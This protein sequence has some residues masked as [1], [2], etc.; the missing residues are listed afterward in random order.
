MS[1]IGI[2]K[3]ILMSKL[4]HTLIGYT[5]QSVRESI[6]ELEDEIRQLKTE[7]DS[8]QVKIQELRLTLRKS[9]SEAE[10]IRE[11][12][13]DAKNLSR[14]LVREAKERATE[15][16][17]EAEQNIDRQYVDFERSIET[18]NHLH[19]DLTT[20][21]VNLE[22]EFQ[23]LLQRCRQSIAEAD[24]GEFNTLNQVFTQQLEDADQV[25]E[26]SRKVIF[27]TEEE[28]IQS[29]NAIVTLSPTMEND[30]DDIPLY[31]FF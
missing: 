13:V 8:Q 17:F 15:M 1:E 26:T 24:T 23:E 3:G 4:K 2:K 29:E 25:I 11:A 18:L 14:R 28:R 10:L 7:R 5:S 30:A 19:T 9:E 27:T 12:V 16:L 31:S 22:Q 20:Q 21:K 6:A